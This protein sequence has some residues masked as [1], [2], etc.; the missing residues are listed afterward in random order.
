MSAPLSHDEAIDAICGCAATV[1]VLSYQEA[2]EAYLN[3]RGMGG[4]P[5]ENGPELPDFKQGFPPSIY[6]PDYVEDQRR[7][8]REDV[9]NQLATGVFRRFVINA[10]PGEDAHTEAVKLFADALSE[11]YKEKL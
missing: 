8:I 10:W 3:L 9:A 2:V 1:T 7:Y 11:A 5:R 4:G 6:W